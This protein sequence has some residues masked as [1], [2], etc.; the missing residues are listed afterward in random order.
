MYQ[1]SLTE[2]QK[3]WG[4][5]RAQL[6]HHDELVRNFD[7]LEKQGAAHDEL[8]RSLGAQWECLYESALTGADVSE[9]EKELEVTCKA[10]GLPECATHDTFRAFLERYR[11]I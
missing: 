9:R 6:A 1:A 4:R 2:Y 10:F 7:A 5:Y 11:V 8:T 3:A